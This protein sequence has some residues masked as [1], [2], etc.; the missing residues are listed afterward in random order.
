MLAGPNLTS[1]GAFFNDLS[2]T[3]K[4]N[5]DGILVPISSSDSPN[6]KT[7]LKNIVA[8][9][10]AGRQD[11][12]NEEFGSVLSKG[13]KLLKYDLQILHDWLQ[14]R[15]VG[16]VVI[17]LQDSEAFDILLI[18]ELVEIFRYGSSEQA[19]RFLYANHASATGSRRSLLFCCLVLQPLLTISQKG[20]PLRLGCYSTAG[21]SISQS[22]MSFSSGHLMLQS[23]VLK[24]LCDWALQSSKCLSNGRK[25]IFCQLI[26]LQTLLK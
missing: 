21:H 23:A 9:A 1:H 5:A 18:A 17:A 26:P 16:K 19:T 8:Y 25:I 4:S 13:R 22:Q 15:N 24:H 12:S 20:Y 10:T 11:D 7:T 6:L 3:L 2:E 14:G